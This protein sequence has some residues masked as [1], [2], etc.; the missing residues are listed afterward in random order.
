M[1]NTLQL[2]LTIFK[3]SCCWEFHS[4]KIIIAPSSEHS[5]TSQT[6]VGGGWHSSWYSWRGVALQLYQQ[7][8][9]LSLLVKESQAI[10]VNRM[11]KCGWNVFNVS[12]YASLLLTRK[13]W[14]NLNN[15]ATENILWWLVTGDQLLIIHPPH[16]Q[17]S[18]L[19]NYWRNYTMFY[20]CFRYVQLLRQHSEVILTLCVF[21]SRMMQR[22]NW[23]I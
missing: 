23:P 6:G 19:V 14:F 5:A 7:E 18:N 1:R 2:L 10:V 12:S 22:I 16:L 20:Y 15:L 4:L 13:N 21:L 8:I 3:I 17:W 9:L 11:W